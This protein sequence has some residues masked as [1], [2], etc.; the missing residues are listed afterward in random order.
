MQIKSATCIPSSHWPNAKTCAKCK[1]R[2]QTTYLCTFVILRKTSFWV[3]VRH[4][5]SRRSELPWYHRKRHTFFSSISHSTASLPHAMT[6]DKWQI[7]NQLQYD[8]I[9]AKTGFLTSDKWQ[10]TRSGLMSSYW[11]GSYY[12]SWQLTYAFEQKP[13]NGISINLH[14]II[15]KQV[16]TIHLLTWHQLPPPLAPSQLCRQ[17]C[18]EHLEGKI[19]WILLFQKLQK[20]CWIL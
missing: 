17:T 16:I 9:W 2:D 8:Q 5:H 18:Q 6:K 3:F 20:A 12:D 14:H 10:M 19:F 1:S 11:I 4:N 7:A 15:T 13:F